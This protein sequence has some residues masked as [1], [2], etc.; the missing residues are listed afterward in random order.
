MSTTMLSLNVKSQPCWI[1]SP[2]RDSPAGLVPIPSPR[3]AHVGVAN[4]GGTFEHISDSPRLG[5][6]KSD[7]PIARSTVM[8][9]A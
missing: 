6:P 8:L 9:L 2:N 7:A 5:S 3:S 4:P 1:L